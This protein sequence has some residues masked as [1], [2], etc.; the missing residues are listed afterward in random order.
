MAE[1]SKSIVAAMEQTGIDRELGRV[2]A[3]CLRDNRAGVAALLSYLMM[4]AL[5]VRDVAGLKGKALA[6]QRNVYGVLQGATPA[7][8]IRL[9]RR[10]GRGLLKKLYQR[11]HTRSP[12]TKSRHRLTFTID[13]WAQAKRSELSKLVGSSYDGSIKKVRRCLNI[14]ALN[15]VIGNSKLNIPLDVDF[16]L[17]R[18]KGQRGRPPLTKA[19][20][21]LAMLDRLASWAEHNAIRLKGCALAVDTWYAS[22]RLFAK[23]RELGMILV[24]K[25]KSNQR[26]DTGRRQSVKVKDLLQQS[27]PVHKSRGADQ[28]RYVRLVATHATFGRT[29]LV[30]PQD[31][32]R[33]EC[34]VASDPTYDGVRTIRASDLRWQTETF[35]WSMKQ[36]LHFGR[37][38]YKSDP[39][40][41]AH[42]G[43]RALGYLLF[44][45]VRCWLLKKK[46][47]RGKLLKIL[48]THCNEW[49]FPLAEQF[50][51]SPPFSHRPGHQTTA[52]GR[53]R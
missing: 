41:F 40:L 33:I 51:L 32:Q 3:R 2:A 44:N 34:L 50:A 48:A 21:A 43:L 19:D 1:Y 38:R 46:L 36:D 10:S 17:P 22:Q 30:I 42:L 16:K 5:G 14:I 6:S 25:A 9:I 13:D 37:C 29:A 28:V 4:P 31:K 52:R 20:L 47:T 26:F 27:L 35:S 11:H 39:K 18:R 15:V 8:F 23:A 45:Y 12:A 53:L 7:S 24:T 49:L